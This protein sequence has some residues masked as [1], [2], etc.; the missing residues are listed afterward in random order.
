MDTSSKSRLSA[1]SALSNTSLTPA[2]P[3][4]GELPEPF[5]IRSSP[6]LPRMLLMD[7]SPGTKRKDS[8]TVGLPAPLGPTMAVI[9]EPNWSAVFLAKDLNPDSSIDVS[10]IPPILAR[11]RP[12][13]LR[14]GVMR[15]LEFRDAA[16]VSG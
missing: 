1:R 14:Y 9:L 13:I 8:A 3:P 11:K 16:E 2:R 4:R 7:C 15:L 6:R 12:S 5:H 10:R